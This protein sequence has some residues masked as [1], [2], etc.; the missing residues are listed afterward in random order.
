VERIFL[1]KFNAE[2]LPNNKVL[3]QVLFR[4]TKGEIHCWSPKWEEVRKLF[5]FAVD[6]ECLNTNTK[7]REVGLFIQQAQ[8]TELTC[9][10]CKGIERSKARKHA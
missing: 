1:K 9:T 4:D 10:L 2:A 8:V 5:D 7:S 6:V 3:L